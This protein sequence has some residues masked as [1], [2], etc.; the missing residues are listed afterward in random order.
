MQVQSD[1]TLRADDLG[2]SQARLSKVRQVI[3]MLQQESQ[4]STKAV[5]D[6]YAWFVDSC[7]GEL[8]IM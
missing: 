4:S 3:T 7:A 1:V 8:K 5:L 6:E 2:K